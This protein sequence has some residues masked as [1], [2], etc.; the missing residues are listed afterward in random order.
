MRRVRGRL[1]W[2]DGDLDLESDPAEADGP[3]VT[4]FVHQLAPE[5]AEALT[6][7][8]LVVFVD[9]HVEG[10]GWEPVHLQEV[11]PVLTANMI[12]HH[13]RP[14]SLLALCASLYGRCPRGYLLTVLGHD[15]DF[16]EELAPDTSRRAD[17]AVERLLALLRAHG[18]EAAR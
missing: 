14:A 1:G 13:L 11:E 8:S 15:F 18:V 17:E 4:C 5:M 9:A 12:S 2:P 16:G 10:A 6:R 7:Y 3:L